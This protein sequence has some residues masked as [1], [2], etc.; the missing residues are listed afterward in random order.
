MFCRKICDMQHYLTENIENTAR[1][2]HIIT[3]TFLTTVNMT[4]FLESMF[5]KLKNNEQIIEYVEEQELFLGWNEVM[6]RRDANN[7]S[8]SSISLTFMVDICFEECVTIKRGSSTLSE[9]MQKY[10]NNWKVLDCLQIDD[11]VEKMTIDEQAE[12]LKGFVV[13]ILEFYD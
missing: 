6:K 11:V 7:F 9:F 8:E 3:V 4:V 13:F 12:W 10:K 2:H 5:A 1:L